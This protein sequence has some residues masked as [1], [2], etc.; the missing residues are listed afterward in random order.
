MSSHI[1]NP[2]RLL[3]HNPDQHAKYMYSTTL[4]MCLGIIVCHTAVI[5][6]III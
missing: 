5:P 1:Y 4:S 2:E 6:A 3:M